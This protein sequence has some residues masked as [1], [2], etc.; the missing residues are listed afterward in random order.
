MFI[1][2]YL[3]QLFSCT[4]ISVTVVQ[5]LKDCKRINKM[6]EIQESLSISTKYLLCTIT[7]LCLNDSVSSCG[8]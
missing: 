6:N 2:S 3:L 5:A 7:I 4:Q 8:D 1:T